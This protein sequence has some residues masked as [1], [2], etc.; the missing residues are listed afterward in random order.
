MIDFSFVQK[1]DWC[2][3]AAL[4]AAN[5]R[6]AL[7]DYFEQRRGAIPFVGQIETTNACS[8]RCLTC[9]RGRRNMSRTVGHMTET[10]FQGL[11]AQM[12]EYSSGYYPKNLYQ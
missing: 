7:F 6:I 10:L 4:L 11:V 9:P 12:Q 1:L 2:E 3:I 8:F 5:D